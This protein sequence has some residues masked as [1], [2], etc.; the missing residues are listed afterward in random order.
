GTANLTA[1]VVACTSA[2]PVGAFSGTIFTILDTRNITLR[3]LNISGGVGVFMQDSRGTFSSVNINGSRS[4]GLSVQGASSLTLMGGT[5]S[6]PSPGVFEA[7]PNTVTNSCG[8]GINV[9]PGASVVFAMLGTI[10]G[11]AGA[12]VIVNG[13]TFAASGCCVVENVGSVV[14]ENNRAGISVGVSGGS[15]SVNGGSTCSGSPGTAA[16]RNNKEWGVIASG[17]SF[18][19]LNGM[20]TLEGNQS[21]PTSATALAYRSAIYG[22]YGA[23][24]FVTPGAVIRTT[25]AGAGVIVDAQS[26]LRL[27]SLPP[28][29]PPGA[30][31]TQPTYPNASITMNGDDG[32]RATNLSFMEILSTTNVMSNAGKDAKCDDTS[33]LS[34]IKSG[35]GSNKCK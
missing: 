10:S 9:G 17:P 33:V 12:G 24:I 20:V 21:A 14:I 32:I 11:N 25:N 35:V 31:C 4:E 22:N 1:P 3:R 8:N 5:L 13:G 19:G 27:G 15:A 30:P 6:G 18:F 28:S 29:L 26:K 16:I 2:A 7:T 34:G 23:T